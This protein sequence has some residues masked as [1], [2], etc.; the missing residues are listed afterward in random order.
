M[1]SG[2]YR[3]GLPE[4]LDHEVA[5][6]ADVALGYPGTGHKAHWRAEYELR[7][8][9]KRG[10]VRD[11]AGRDLSIPPGSDESL[12]HGVF[13]PGCPF[14]GQPGNYHTSCMKVCQLLYGKGYHKEGRWCPPVS[15]RWNIWVRSDAPLAGW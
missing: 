5:M 14:V 8:N 7:Q 4:W 10:R 12:G 2:M 9:A 11:S 3:S 15:E 6:D 13:V 1:P